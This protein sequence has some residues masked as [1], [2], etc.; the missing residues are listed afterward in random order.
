MPENDLPELQK[1]TRSARRRR[2]VTPREAPHVYA[3][4]AIVLGL[5]CQSGVS[6]PKAA[7]SLLGIPAVASSGPAC[8]NCDTVSNEENPTP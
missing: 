5:L 2:P 4:I 7:W 8:T 6:I 1:P 3:I